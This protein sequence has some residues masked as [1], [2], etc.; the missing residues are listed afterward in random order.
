MAMTKGWMSMNFSVLIS[1]TRDFQ[2]WQDCYQHLARFLEK[3]QKVKPGFWESV[4]EREQN[5]PTGLQMTPN[6]GI[7]I[8]HP[9]D[10]TLTLESTIA[11]SVLSH[12]VE[13]RSMADPDEKIKVSVVLMLAL[14]STEDHLSL[15]E[16]MMGTFQNEE[17]IQQIF[18]LQE[19]KT[20]QAFLE[21]KLGK[22]P[23]R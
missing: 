19:P 20:I 22:T 18:T 5:F 13:V 9:S 16:Q 10:P 4:L 6:F 17:L 11:V 2:D 7:A 12:P 1:P 15:L 23:A 14:K 3:E 21:E 8:P